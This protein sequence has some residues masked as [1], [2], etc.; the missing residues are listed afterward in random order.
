MGGDAEEIGPARR[1]LSSSRLGMGS[2]PFPGGAAFRVWSPHAEAV[3]VVGDFN[4]WTDDRDRPPVEAG[5]IGRVRCATPR[6]PDMRLHHLE[7]HTAA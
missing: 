1:G 5:A 7:W 4:G 2:L 6:G 3:S